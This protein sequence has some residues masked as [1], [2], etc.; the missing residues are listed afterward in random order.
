MGNI[1]TK[2]PKEINGKEVSKP[3]QKRPSSAKDKKTKDEHVTYRLNRNSNHNNTEKYT[4]IKTETEHNEIIP[5][6]KSQ[7]LSINPELTTTFGNKKSPPSYQK[8]SHTKAKICIS[9]DFQSNETHILK[10]VKKH[11]REFEDSQL[12]ETCLMNNS[13]MQSLDKQARSE[14]VKQMS[15]CFVQKDTVIFKQGMMGS[16]FYILKQGTVELLIN[17]KVLKNLNEGENFGELALL[18]GAPRSGT[19]IA[20]TDC[21][22]WVMERKNFRKI[23]AHITYTNYEENKKFIHS[24]PILSFFESAQK[25]LLCSSL[26]KEVFE[27]DIYIIKQGEL[28]SCMYCIREGDVDIESNGNKIRTL[29]KGDYFG[30][31]SILI[32]STRTMNAI[33]RTK[34]LCFSFS[35]TTLKNMLGENYRHL[36]LINFIKSAFYS[37]KLFHHLHLK[38]IDN[39]FHLFTLRILRNKEIA[40]PKGY[41]SSSKV[42]VLIDGTLIKVS[43]KIIYTSIIVRSKRSIS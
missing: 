8:P 12:I 29:H 33:S 39:V 17:E 27:P 15:L 11:N 18:Y 38:M 10:F 6:D 2:E 40:F 28:A 4:P 30:E 16:Y 41:V 42:V 7:T 34:C 19:I 25:S 20:K 13:F 21:F 23:V 35:V 37:S 22:I 3:T 36:M 26:Y 32:D 31:K 24:T 43:K 5:T 1:C 14:I 9:S